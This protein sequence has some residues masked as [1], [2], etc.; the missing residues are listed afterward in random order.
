[1]LEV[2][3]QDQELLLAQETGEVVARPDRL[4][5]LRREELGIRQAGERRPEDAVPERADELGCDLKRFPA[6]PG[7]VM[8]SNR[9]LWE[10]RATSSRTSCTLPT[11]GLAATGRLVASRVRSGGKSPSPS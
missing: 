3:E 9:V 2:V 1:M 10:S 4:R 5:Y 8:V 6:P 11:S 7:P